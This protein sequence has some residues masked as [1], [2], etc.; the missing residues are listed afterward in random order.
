LR[1]N[2]EI[3][4]VIP[5]YRSRAT[6]ELSVASVLAQKTTHPFELLI[7]ESGG[8]A[9]AA[10]LTRILPTQRIFN[11]EVRLYP[12]AARN[13]GARQASGEYLAFLDADVVL[14]P[15]WL[16]TLLARLLKDDRI[17]AVAAPVANANPEQRA[18]RVL[19]WVEFSEYLPGQPSGFRPALSSSNLL[20]RRE[21]FLETGGFAEHLA[22]GEDLLFSQKLKYSLFLE[23]S[24]AV[25]HR[26]RSD[27]HLV[28]GHLRQLGYWSGRHRRDHRSSGDWLRHIPLLSFGLPALRYVRILRR[29]SRS[30]RANGLEALVLTPWVVAALFHWASG[31][32]QGVTSQEQVPT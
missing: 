20:L 13:A 22:M 27:W 18:S 15:A 28:A 9:E 1:Q 14:P 25:C 26:H 17:K 24:L 21:T 29:V 11:S 8:Q 12:G 23:T 6:V 10:E 3:S 7:V 2:P 19:H 30:D 16:E 5:S 31:F 32:R 4:F